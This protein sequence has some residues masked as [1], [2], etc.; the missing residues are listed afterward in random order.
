MQY[1]NR[2][3]SDLSLDELEAIDWELGVKEL[4]HIEAMKHPKFEKIKPVPTLGQA[5][6]DLREAVRQEIINKSVDVNLRINK[7]GN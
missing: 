6:L 2:P 3:I 7:N 5:F 1:K 4:N